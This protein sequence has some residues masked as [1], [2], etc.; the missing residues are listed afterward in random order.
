MLL[1]AVVVL[2]GALIF[3][4]IQIGLYS[5][6]MI[7]VYTL[8]FDNF[9]EGRSKGKMAI[10]ITEQP[11]QVIEQIGRVL[12]RGCTHLQGKGSY[13]QKDKD[14]LMCAVTD[15]QAALLRSSIA[16]KDPAAFVM[17]L[18]ATEIWGEGFFE[19]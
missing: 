15:R 12:E 10:I 14:I 18:R 16:Q 1:D 11:Q 13:T 9:L 8:V 5:V 7:F 3:R 6:L 19:L 2:S 17:V 4:S